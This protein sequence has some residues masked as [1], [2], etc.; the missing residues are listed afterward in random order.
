M[1][2]LLIGALGKMGTQMQRFMKQHSIDFVAVDKQNF[3]SC[4]DVDFDVIVDFSCAEALKQNLDLATQKQKPIL[5]ATTNHDATNEH[6]L[7][8]ASKKIAI[9]VCPNL[10]VG[11]LT[12]S[13]MIE[14][15]KPI[16]TFDFVLTETHHKQKKDAP[17]GTAKQF[18][19]ALSKQGIIP[20]V[21]AI[22]AG[23]IV[24][25]HTIT[26]IGENEVVEIKHTAIT[27][28][29]FCNGAIEVCKSLINKSAG[30]YHIEDLL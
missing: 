3:N 25:E 12:V 5:I 7:K 9:A 24:G 16:N 22:R 19:N 4:F 10:S 8:L 21:V 13:K 26:A 2:I 14:N 20:Q 27:R 29:C 28:D 17:S 11:V 23:Q 15:F 18:L 30:L 6:M 1:K